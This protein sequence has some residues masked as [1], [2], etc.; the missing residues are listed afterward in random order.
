MNTDEEGNEMIGKLH[1]N[2]AGDEQ[3]AHLIKGCATAL[4]NIANVLPR[5]NWDNLDALVERL[6]TILL[7]T[8]GER[9][10]NQRTLGYMNVANEI[11]KRDMANATAE[12]RGK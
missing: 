2:A 12:R 9:V 8:M 1:A 3:L 10:K 7:I 6:N 5:E 4:E 11:A